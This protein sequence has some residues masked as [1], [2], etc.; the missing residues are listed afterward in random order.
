MVTDTTTEA[1][2]LGLEQN[3][4]GDFSYPGDAHSTM[5]ASG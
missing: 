1:S 2:P 3:T 5:P 4:A